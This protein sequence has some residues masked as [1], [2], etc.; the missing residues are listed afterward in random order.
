MCIVSFSQ[1]RIDR[2]YIPLEYFTSLAFR[3][4]FV[5]PTELNR[6]IL[7]ALMYSYKALQLAKAKLC[8]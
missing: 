1:K 2:T 7:V 6:Q 5:T 8:L 4:K 3:M